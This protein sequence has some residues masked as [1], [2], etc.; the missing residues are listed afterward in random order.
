MFRIFSVDPPSS[1]IK[2]KKSPQN[3]GPLSTDN[4]LYYAVEDLSGTDTRTPVDNAPNQPDLLYN[5]L[6]EPY[7][8]GS[9]DPVWYGSSTADGPHYN[10]LEGPYQY[11]GSPRTNEPLYNVLEAPS[12]SGADE[13]SSYGSLIVQNPV[14]DALQ[15]PNPDKSSENLLYSSSMEV[16]HPNDS[17][18]VPVYAVAYEK[19]K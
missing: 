7:A 6:Q 17:E 16:Q 2:R 8:K 5:A 19:G 9:D 18:N 1:F 15:G 14:Y 10:T 4:P 11:G 3:S 12:P 13:E